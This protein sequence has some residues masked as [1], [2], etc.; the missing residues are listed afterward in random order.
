MHNQKLIGLVTVTYNSEEVLPDF[1]RSVAIQTHKNFILYVIDNASTDESLTLLRNWNDDRIRLIAN[2]ENH[3]IAGGNN[4]GIQQALQDGCDSILLINNDTQF[5]E[6]LISALA[7][8]LYAHP[9]GIVCPK[10]MY[11]DE[12]Q[13]FWA[14]GG[15]FDKRL[16]YRPVHLAAEEIDRGQCNQARFIDYTPT[17]CTLIRKSVFAEV[18]LMDERY[19]VYFDDVDFMYRAVMAGIKILY[20]P[21]TTLLHKVGR[22]T[23]GSTSLFSVRYCTRNRVYFLR[24]HLGPLRTFATLLLYEFYYLAALLSGRINLKVYSLK[25][26]ATWEGLY[27]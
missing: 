18:G 6:D 20:S 24:K 1:L 5:N 21:T 22:L 10:I 11:F 25:H 27:M 13:R 16:G 12:P 9:V 8:E 19:F 23:G 2:S 3:G 14:A 17:C 4:Q 15:R 26:K 7:R